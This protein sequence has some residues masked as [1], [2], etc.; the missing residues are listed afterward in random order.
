M[1][2]WF[3]GII[4][5]KNKKVLWHPDI[6]SHTEL[7]E[8]FK[9]KDETKSPNFVRVEF[10]PPNNDVFNHDF[11]NWKFKTDQDFRQD[12][13]DEEKSK[14]LML[15][16]VKKLIDER[17]VID[18]NLDEIK[19]GRWWVGGKSKVNKV[20][21]SAQIQSVYGSARIEYVYGSA[22]IK[23]V[24]DS[25]RIESVSD[26]ARIKYVSDSAQ[27]KSVSD[28]ARIESVYGSA[29]IQSVSDSAR[30]KYVSDSAQIQYVSD[31]AQ[32]KYVSDSAQIKSVYGSARI[33]SVSDSAIA[34]LYSDKAKIREIKDNGL[35][36]VRFSKPHKILT[37]KPDIKLELF[38]ANK[39]TL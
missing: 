14:E 31:S 8:H 26:S 24:S 6:D 3:S 10:T 33:E 20:C 27:I 16:A 36:I 17:F 25:A 35:A 22:R 23:Y 30:I 39:D 7:L 28:S 1:C 15:S 34:Q 29:Q 18:R 32:I 38:K 37:G 2:N 21:D 12:W 11:K 19:V 9:I 4:V 13:Y 5:D